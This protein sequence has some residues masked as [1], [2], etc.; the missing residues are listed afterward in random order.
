MRKILNIYEN[1]IDDILI[2]ISEY[3]CPYF[4]KCSMTPNNITTLSL[5]TGVLSIFFLY[6]NYFIWTIIYLFLSYFFDIV[7]GH[8]A[9]KYKMETEFGDLYDHIKDI[10]VNFCIFFL[11]MYKTYIIDK[12]LMY[13][14]FFIIIFFYICMNFHLGCQERM[15]DNKENNNFL[16]YNTYL[17]KKK[18]YIKYSRYVGCATFYLVVFILIFI[19]KSYY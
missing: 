5:I 2:D 16:H 4:K 1:P 7:D 10:I 3:L 17:C 18:E 15:Y 8:F 13:I 14:Y 11:L 12:K 19:L 9:R 6:H